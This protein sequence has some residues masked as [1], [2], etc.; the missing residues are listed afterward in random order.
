MVGV[1][2]VHF[3]RGLTSGEYIKVFLRTSEADWAYE[4]VTFVAVK[5]CCPPMR[6]AKK[7]VQ[8]NISRIGED[9]G[10]LSHL[11]LTYRNRRAIVLLSDHRESRYQ[12]SSAF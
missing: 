11:Y 5:C 3:N 4:W 8:L 2:Y 1:Q 6:N 7:P 12:T 10:A 9:T